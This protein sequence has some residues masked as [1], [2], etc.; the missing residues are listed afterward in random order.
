MRS[1]RVFLLLSFSLTWAICAALYFSGS[2]LLPSATLFL[3]ACMLMPALSVLLTKLITREGW[4]DIGFRPRFRGH[5]RYYLAAWLG[6]PLLIAAGG[7]L[8]FLLR[9]ES[10]DSSL[11]AASALSGDAALTPLE[12]KLSIL[13]Q[14][15]FAAV[16]SPLL[17]IVFC[18]GEELGWRGY[19]LPKLLEQYGMKK[20]LLLSGLIWG[21]WHAPMIAMGHNYGVGYPGWP[22]LGIIAMCLFCFCAGCFFA[23][24]TLRSGSFWPAAVAHGAMNGFA[25]ASLMFLTSGYA[26]DPFVGPLPTGYIGG[27][28]LIAVGLLCF[29]TLRKPAIAVTVPALPQAEYTA[30]A[31]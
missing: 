3:S 14:L 30:A 12:L 28:F 6:T 23:W 4:R 24:V 9:P 11:A 21:L 18:T 22:W 5:L 2:Y 7:A 8:F 1:I 19:L 29:F 10:F 13:A 16:I 20:A 26:A 15:L 17:N 25:G 31:D 27:A